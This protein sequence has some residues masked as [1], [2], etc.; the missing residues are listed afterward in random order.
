MTNKKLISALGA[1]AIALA[2]YF[3]NSYLVSKGSSLAEVL[4]MAEQ[5]AESVDRI[6]D[7]AIDAKT[8][9]EVL[10]GDPSPV[11]DVE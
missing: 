2:T 7:K 5:A 10:T 9:I 1:I 6:A 3:A 4:G 11:T 8:K